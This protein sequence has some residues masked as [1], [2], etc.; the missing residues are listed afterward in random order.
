LFY[1]DGDLIAFPSLD[2]L[3]LFA[4][5]DEKTIRNGRDRLEAAGLLR[6]QHRF[7]NSNFYCLTIAAEAENHLHCEIVLNRLPKLPTRAPVENDTK[8]PTTDPELGTQM[9]G[10]ND[11]KLSTT[12]DLTSEY[13]NAPCSHRSP[14]GSLARLEEEE[15][16]RGREEETQEEKSP[17]FLGHQPKGGEVDGSQT[18]DDVRRAEIGRKPAELRETLGRGLQAMPVDRMRRH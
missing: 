14:A 2:R 5:V 10:E 12:S 13:S 9:G 3:A 7:D 18:V 16:W 1:R 6:I 11:T 8:L 4:S 17:Q 15:A